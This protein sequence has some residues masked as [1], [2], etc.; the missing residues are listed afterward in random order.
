MTLLFQAVKFRNHLRNRLADA[1]VLGPLRMQAVQRTRTG[2][3][4]AVQKSA[5]VGL[6][7][8][9]ISTAA[10][11]ILEVRFDPAFA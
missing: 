4:L 1:D 9:S 2:V 7:N 5:P 11:K 10:Q 6:S 8:L 3:K